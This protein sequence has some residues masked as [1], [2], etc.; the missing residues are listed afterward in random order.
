MKMAEAIG[1]SLERGAVADVEWMKSQGHEF[2][3]LSDA[4]RSEFLAPLDVFTEG[5]KTKICKGLDP[6][7]VDK[8]YKFARERSRY[9][10]EQVRA[11]KYG[12]YGR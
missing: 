11:G 1:K 6:R 5:W 8:V 4:E 3:E 9:Y 10:T 7:L 12:D 2:Y